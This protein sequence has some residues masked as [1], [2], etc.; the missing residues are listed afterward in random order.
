M[1]D[2]EHP[3]VRAGILRELPV[4]VES[5]SRRSKSKRSESFEVDQE[6]SEGAFI[7]S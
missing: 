1:T 3:P 2:F 6:I 5:T 7:E 4:S